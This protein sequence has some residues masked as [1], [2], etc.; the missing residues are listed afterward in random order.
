MPQY[1]VEFIYKLTEIK[2]SIEI[3][4]DA[5][6]RILNT[7]KQ[8][9]EG[10]EY[11]YV[12]NLLKIRSAVSTFIEVT[13]G[14]LRLDITSIFFEYEL[15]QALDKFFPDELLLRN[16]NLNTKIKVE[17]TGLGKAYLKEKIA[18]VESNGVILAD[19][20]VNENCLE[21]K[22]WEFIALFGDAMK[23][24]GSNPVI[25]SEILIVR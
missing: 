5:E 16:I 8:P 21:L 1:C 10:D 19:Y 12:R 13:L 18:E 23:V 11:T 22:L 15:S 6:R 9:Q 24:K 7:E 25:K 4:N 20:S 2:R 17:L 3:K 14:L